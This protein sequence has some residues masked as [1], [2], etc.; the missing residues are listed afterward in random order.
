MS[1]LNNTF[2][3]L[4]GRLSLVL[5]VFLFSCQNGEEEVKAEQEVYFEVAAPSSGSGRVEDDP[6]ITSFIISIETISGESI[7][8]DEEIKVTLFESSY[9]SDPISLITGDYNLTKFLVMSEEEVVYASPLEDAELA[10]LVTDPLPIEFTVAAD[11]VSTVRPEVLEVSEGTITEF[12]YTEFSFEITETFDLFVAVLAYDLDT[13]GYELQHATITVSS[14]GE[15]IVEQDLTAGTNKVVLPDGL[16]TYELR[17]VKASYDTY[18]QAFTADSL[19]NYQG[20]SIHGPLEIILTP[21]DVTE[22]L[23]AF[24]PFNGNAND[25][26]GNNLHGTPS[27][28]VLTEDRHGNANSA[29]YF[30]GIN[31]L[32]EAP[33]SSVL[34]SQIY[35]LSLWFNAEKDTGAMI[36]LSDFFPTEN[37]CGYYL[38]ILDGKLR[39][40]NQIGGFQWVR[41][42]DDDITSINEWHHVVATYDGEVIKTYLNGALVHTHEDSHVIDFSEHNPLMIGTYSTQADATWFQGSLDEVRIYDRVLSPA[43]VEQLYLL[44]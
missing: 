31:D 23:V 7:L 9:L 32:I 3:S 41:S 12:G 11:E 13:K 17:V 30:D 2:F 21:G 22:G 44:N 35:S 40:Q 37:N 14:D 6:V 24:F 42:I 34:E 1:F 27:G 36:S 5:T 18:T 33:N 26:S 8:E 4:V 19:K 43:E 25:E 20:T 10:Y 39:V 29:Y 38:S 28:A 16:N 15:E